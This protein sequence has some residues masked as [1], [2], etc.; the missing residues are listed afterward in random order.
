MKLAAFSKTYQGRCVLDFPGMELLPGR[1]YAV[2]G[3]NGSGKSTFARIL[4]G[5]LCA[6]RP[7]AARMPAPSAICP[8]KTM[9]SG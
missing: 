4:A 2:I 3:A 7:A 9:P 8:R 5:V 1:I 6:D